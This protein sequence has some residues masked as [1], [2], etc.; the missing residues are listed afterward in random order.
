MEK[1]RPTP[2]STS[3]PTSSTEP[4]AG[5]TGNSITAATPTP[6]LQDGE[7]SELSAEQLARMLKLLRLDRY[8]VTEYPGQ[9]RAVVPIPRHI[10]RQLDRGIV[11][12]SLSFHRWPSLVELQAHLCK[13]PQ[14]R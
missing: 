1:R 3:V 11:L 6:E 14:P 9:A 7:P 2:V 12:Q 13:D 8:M 10:Q 5:A 4:Q